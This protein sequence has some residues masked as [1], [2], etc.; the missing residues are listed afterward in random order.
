MSINETSDIVGALLV[1]I[2]LIRLC[3]IDIREARLPDRYT[4]PLIC[5]GIA[6]N[7]IL[8]REL[9]A[10][11]LWGSIV[12]YIVFW[13]LGEVFFRWRDRE[14]L[15]LGDAKL[16]SAAG[17]WLGI[18]ALPTLVLIAAGSALGYAVLRGAPRDV[19]LPFGPFLAFAFWLLLLIWGPVHS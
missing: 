9:P 4:L 19:P 13:L 7:G 1:G 2:V 12:G 10:L 17:A 16:L 3:M 6:Y 5:T 14:G 11:S 18:M 8:S 15:G